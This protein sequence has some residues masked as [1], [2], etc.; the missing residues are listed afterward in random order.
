[1]RTARPGTL[2]NRVPGQ[3][4]RAGAGDPRRGQAGDQEGKPEGRGPPPAHEEPRPGGE[5]D[6]YI[7]IYIYIYKCSQQPGQNTSLHTHCKTWHL[8]NNPYLQLINPQYIASIA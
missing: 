7:Y 3:G 4:G 8:S 5:R 2:Q 6:E 1:M